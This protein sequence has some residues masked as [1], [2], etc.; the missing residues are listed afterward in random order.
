MIGIV[1]VTHGR[2]AEELVKA[3]RAIVGEIPGI[4]AVSIGWTDDP[5]AANAAIEKAIGEVGAGGGVLILTDMFGGTPTNL[6]LSYLS[7]RVEIV[8]G[9]NLP[10]LIKLTSL[11]EGDLREVARVVHD[12]G[13]GAIYVA[14]EFLE[15]KRS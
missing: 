9:V 10:M 15:K 4:A 2:L 1:V 6:S 14:S 7:P 13:K 12:Q 3:A 5:S 8:T 11:R